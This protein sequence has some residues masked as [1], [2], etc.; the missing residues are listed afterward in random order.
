LEVRKKCGIKAAQVALG[1]ARADVTQ[2]YAE[3]NM[4]MAMRIARETG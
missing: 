1:H 3:R 4:E 2:V